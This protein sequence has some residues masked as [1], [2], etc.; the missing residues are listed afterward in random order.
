MKKRTETRL[1]LDGEPELY[2]IILGRFLEPSVDE[3]SVEDGWKPPKPWEIVQG[4]GLS[5]GAFMHWVDDPE[6]P[7]R[8]VRFDLNLRTR[9]QLYKEQ[10]I[11]IVD[12]AR[13]EKNA[14]SKA[15]LRKRARDDVAAA[16][17]KGRYAPSTKLD[18]SMKGGSLIAV[19]AALDAQQE[20]PAIE[21]DVTPALPAPKPEY[22]EL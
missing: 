5:F 20:P 22:A 7:E 17:D 9:A 1:L 18:V 8:R 6:H 19:L 10:T 14:L 3:T 11:D 13:E 4:M 21:L 12:G 2:G 15:A 16:W